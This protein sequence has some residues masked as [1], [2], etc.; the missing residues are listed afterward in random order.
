MSRAGAPPEDS[1]AAGLTVAVLGSAL[2]PLWDAAG[3]WAQEVPAWYGPLL[4]RLAAALGVLGVGAWLL[5]GPALLLLLRPAGERLALVVTSSFSLFV[6]TSA[7]ARA[8]LSSWEEAAGWLP[9]ALWCLFAGLFAGA[10][11]LGR[12]GLPR[13]MA[14]A[15]PLVLAASLRAELLGGL[16]AGLG[17]ALFWWLLRW[18]WRRAPEL[19]LDSPSQARRAA[20]RSDHA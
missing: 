3:R 1:V 13:G 5:A 14:L 8:S 7:A 18:A 15:V 11:V 9:L 12:A 19:A 2:L 6:C 17:A 10:V 16:A 4:A 20:P